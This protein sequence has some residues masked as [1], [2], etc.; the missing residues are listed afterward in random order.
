MCVCWGKPTLSVWWWWVIQLGLFC[1]LSLC[2]VC[3]HKSHSDQIIQ[4]QH[5]NLMPP[6]A[7]HRLPVLNTAPSVPLPAPFAYS[8]CP[9]CRFAMNIT[10]GGWCFVQTVA[11]RRVSF[12]KSK[13]NCC[14]TSYLKNQV[15]LELSS[16]LQQSSCWYSCWSHDMKSFHMHIDLIEAVDRLRLIFDYF[17]ENQ[18][19]TNYITETNNVLVFS[20]WIRMR[21]CVYVKDLDWNSGIQ[22]KLN[23]AVLLAVLDHSYHRYCFFYNNFINEKLILSDLLDTMGPNV[24]FIFPPL[25]ELV[26]WRSNAN[27]IALWLAD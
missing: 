9:C 22:V 10:P 27:F 20:T 24:L 4:P 18:T 13:H 23:S 16:N 14:P 2:H 26:S 5:E 11:H 17:G 7:V 6:T 15:M 21:L 1:F 25:P 8:S 19:S 12:L 3:D